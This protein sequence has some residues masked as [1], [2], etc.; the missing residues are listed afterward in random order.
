MKGQANDHVLQTTA[1][2]NEAAIRILNTDEYSFVDREHVLRVA[3]NAMKQ[4]LIDYA[5]SK[6]ALKRRP[7]GMRV[8]LNNALA[9]DD[10]DSDFEGLSEALN[11]LRKLDSRAADV[12]EYRYFL[13][14]T[15]AQIAL[16]QHRDIGD[17]QKDWRIARAWLRKEL[18]CG[19]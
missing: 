10:R 7:P 17:I 13:E 11:R 3:T 8:S 1:L 6:A 15:F 5:R 16:V 14:L 19:I 9:K 18:S 4:V 12:V 2:M